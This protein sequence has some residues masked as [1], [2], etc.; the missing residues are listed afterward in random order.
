LMFWFN[1][2]NCGRLRQLIDTLN[3]AY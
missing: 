3:R 2:K 1:R